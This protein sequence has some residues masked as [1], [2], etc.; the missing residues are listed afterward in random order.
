VPGVLLDIDESGQA[1]GLEV[2]GLRELGLAQ[3]VV[4]VELA[5]RPPHADVKEGRLAEAMFGNG[6]QQARAH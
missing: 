6:P 5:Q 1:V 2:V 3:G 4:E